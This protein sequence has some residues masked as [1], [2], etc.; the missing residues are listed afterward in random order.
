MIVPTHISKPTANTVKPTA[1]PMQQPI[2]KNSRPKMKNTADSLAT[3][4]DEI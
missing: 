2:T 4:L 3:F 1:F